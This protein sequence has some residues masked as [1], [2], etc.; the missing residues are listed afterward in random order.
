ME[1]HQVRYFLAVSR[2]LNFTR[3]AEHCNVAQPSL[4]RAIRQLEGELGGDLFR[5]ERPHAQLTELGQRM[6]PLLRQCY[7]SAVGARSLASSLRTGEVGALRLALSQGIDINL[8]LPLAA[9]LSRHFRNLE[10]KLLRGTA[11]DVAGFLKRGDAE[12]A[13]AAPIGED[14]ERFDSWPLF[15]ERFSLIASAGHRVAGRG[16]IG[17]HELRDERLLVRSYC[18]QAGEFAELMR[19]HDIDV[20]RG[21]E[22]ASERDL[23]ALVEANLGVAVVPNSTQGPPALTRASIN[24]LDLSRTVYL[25]AVAGRERTAV[26]SAAF[27]LLRAG[28][29]SKYAS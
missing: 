27:K 25:Y 1:M 28:N 7:D 23:I 17:L 8:L 18:E 26:A 15:T 24:G 11:L 29:W 2:T 22:L 6:L 16:E 14:W 12:L 4:T 9:E 20:T 21:H 19:S 3:A 10:L 13:I 5:R